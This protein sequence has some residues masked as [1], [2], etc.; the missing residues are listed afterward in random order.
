MSEAGSTDALQGAF[1]WGDGEA[2]ATAASTA[3]AIVRELYRV[4]G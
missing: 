1:W 2:P 4:L 3:E